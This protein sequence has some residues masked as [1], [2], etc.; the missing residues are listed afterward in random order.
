MVRALN[1][2]DGVRAA[3]ATTD[4]DG[5]DGRLSAADL[6]PDVPVHMF[7]RTCSEQWKLSIG[8]R[9]W[10]AR[11]TGEYDI[12]H[13]HAVWSFA[14]ATAA[15]AAARHNIPYIVR[16][17][18]ML[19]SYSWNNRGWRKRLY[20]S[21][22]ERQTIQK[23]AGFH[24]TSDEEAAEVRGVRADAKVFVITNG[25]EDA[26]FT[27]PRDAAD[28][29]R[30]C[31]ANAADKP[32]VLFLSRLHPIKGIVDRLLPAVASMRSPCFLA[33]VGADDAHSPGH[34]GDVMA[35]IDGLG[36]RGRVALLGA[37]T[38]SQRW[39]LFDG[40]DAF[41]LP[42]HSENFGVVVA[43]AMARGC[44][45]VVTQAVQS[46]EHVAAARA[47]EVVPGD[48]PALASALDRVLSEPELRT[49]YRASGRAYARRHF[50]WD[51]IA[52]RVKRMYADCL[53][54]ERRW[55]SGR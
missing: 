12:V 35:A 24:A 13:I 46:C 23:A 11:H 31:G 20:W 1:A 10:L 50:C 30:R 6:P 40:A 16:P 34:S 27:A 19:S 18:G 47:G 43:E 41:V 48:V 26:A 37:V 49:V 2:I 33:I 42:S 15:R 9:R 21:L 38:G 52:Q 7:R 5:A 29:R 22:V 55:F 44:P 36:L 39:P 3:I 28:L 17:A 25:V 51:E 45:A 53:A 32:I 8:L 4:A 14:T 54:T